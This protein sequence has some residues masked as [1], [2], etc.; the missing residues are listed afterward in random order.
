[1]TSGLPIS[2]KDQIDVKGVN[3]TMSYISRIGEKAERDAVITEIL[4]KQ[5]VWPC[6]PLQAVGSAYARSYSS[7]LTHRPCCIARP[8]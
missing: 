7:E 8:S 3:H 4:L 2:L 5:E 1:M 6:Y